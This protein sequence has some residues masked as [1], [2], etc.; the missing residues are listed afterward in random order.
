MLSHR[1]LPKSLK[2]K[3]QSD[4]QKEQ[5][6]QL[7]DKGINDILE[8]NPDLDIYQMLQY[9]ENDNDT[10]TAQKIA[11]HISRHRLCRS[12]VLDSIY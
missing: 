1:N 2:E 9:Y 3:I 12:F 6:K 11:E 4:I 7:K 5:D 8:R 10:I